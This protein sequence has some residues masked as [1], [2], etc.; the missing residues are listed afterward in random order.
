[1]QAEKV[2]PAQLRGIIN[3]FDFATFSFDM[4]TYPKN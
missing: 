2:P 1:M 4:M 3:S